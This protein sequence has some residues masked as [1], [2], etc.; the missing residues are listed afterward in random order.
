MLLVPGPPIKSQVCSSPKLQVLHIE[1]LHIESTPTTQSLTSTCE[2]AQKTAMNTPA[3]STEPSDA[4]SCDHGYHEAHWKHMEEMIE[5]MHIK[6]M[7]L[8]DA[9]ESNTVLTGLSSLCHSQ[10]IEQ[11]L[12]T[13]VEPYSP[14][15]SC[16]DMFRTSPH[17][18]REPLVRLPQGI[19]ND[20]IDQTVTLQKEKLEALTRLST[21]ER[22]E[23]LSRQT[24]SDCSTK[25]DQLQ[26]RVEM[27]KEYKAVMSRD[28]RQK[29]AMICQY[30]LENQ[31]LKDQVVQFAAT[32]GQLEK[33]RAENDF[34]RTEA[35]KAIEAAKQSEADSKS[36]IQPVD[37]K[38]REIAHLKDEIK[39]LEDNITRIKAQN[40]SHQT[41]A[42]NL[43]ETQTVR[44]KKL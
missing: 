17:Q 4:S 33:L 14:D 39:R 5:D 10:Q 7:D 34:L 2:N 43:A 35:S 30:E 13:L 38:D 32:Q 44:E 29:D 40:S 36:F 27:N 23:H 41:R 21:M 28:I 6:S 1:D 9:P 12:H 20:M 25:F 15:S 42:D 8:E 18:D 11:P 16:K 37:S 24:T 3:M 22:D 19:W 31:A 26:Y